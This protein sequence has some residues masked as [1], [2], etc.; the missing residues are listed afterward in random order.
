MGN[1]VLSARNSVTSAQC[2]QMRRFLS[3]SADFGK[4]SATMLTCVLILL[5]LFR[6][7]IKNSVVRCNMIKICLLKNKIIFN[8]NNTDSRKS[9]HHNVTTIDV[10]YYYIIWTDSGGMLPDAN[11][12][13]QEGKYQTIKVLQGCIL[14]L[15]LHSVNSAP[16]LYRTGNMQ[17]AI[18]LSFVAFSSLPP[19]GLQSTYPWMPC[20]ISPYVVYNVY[21]YN[22]PQCQR[23]IRH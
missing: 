2:S 23:R 10:I 22:R 17:F 4:K 19:C 6:K 3:T 5:L 1:S 7:N 11:T 9:I 12:Q 21:S 14:K 20:Y 16:I 8:E 13:R 18:L 15:L